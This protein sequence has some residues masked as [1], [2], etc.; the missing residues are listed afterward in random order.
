VTDIIERA[1]GLI[2]R[3]KEDN[4]T[5][6]GAVHMTL[7][8]AREVANQL[9][10]TRVRVDPETIAALEA[11]GMS[12]D[13]EKLR[14]QDV[15]EH[16]RVTRMR[17]NLAQTGTVGSL[18]GVPLVIHEDHYVDLW[19]TAEGPEGEESDG[20]NQAEPGS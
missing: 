1:H 4:I 18:W 2:R 6:P 3:Y 11:A 15:E 8:A 20:S 7:A 10:E 19:C 9:D 14:A 5:S 17:H 13:A 12:T 16:E